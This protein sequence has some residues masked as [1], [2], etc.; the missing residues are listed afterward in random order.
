M[1]VPTWNPPT[2]TTAQ[3]DRLL[4][5]LQRT[6]KLFAFLR[7]SRRRI[8]DDGFQAELS[9]MYRQT[10]EGRQPVAPALLAMALLLQAYCGASDAEAVELTVVDARWQLVLGRVGETRPAFSQGALQAFRQRLIEHDLDRR[11]LER[12]AELAKTSGGF[13]HKKLPKL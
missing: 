5:R 12:T 9:A 6:K 10:G 3:E 7:L 2:E 11:L 8:F 4:T 1:S 13:D